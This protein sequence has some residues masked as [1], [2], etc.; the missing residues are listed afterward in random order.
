LQ[1][2]GAVLWN[3]PGVR[4]AGLYG[5][6]RA[7]VE[8]DDGRWTDVGVIDA[9]LDRTLP[10]LPGGATLRLAAEGALIWGAT[11]RSTSYNERGA[12]RVTSGGLTGVLTLAAPSSVAALHLRGGWASADPS[13]DDGWSNDFSFDRD[14]DVGMVL[15]DQVGGGVEAAAHALITDPERSGQPPDGIA[16]IA[17]EGAFRRALFVQP[18]GEFRP[19][20]WLTAKAGVLLAMAS[21]PVQHPFYGHRAGGVPRNQYNGEPDG[22]GL[23]VEFDWS[24]AAGTPIL[25]KREGSPRLEAMLQGGHL[26]MGEA[27]RAPEGCGEACAPES[28]HQVIVG[29]R[30]RW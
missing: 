22:P 26:R 5:V 23:G 4:A 3:E 2:V 25:P 14:F 21:G 6:F 13:P 9:Y 24:L 28:A 18:I 7:Q 15:F 19:L 17:T 12:L 30:F 27:M 20:P 1:W 11:N 8:L 16:A 29:A 10:L